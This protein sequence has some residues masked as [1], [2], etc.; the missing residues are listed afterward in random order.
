VSQQ[1]L[2][3]WGQLGVFVHKRRLRWRPI[4]WQWRGE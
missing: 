1:K 2:V 3:G 4:P